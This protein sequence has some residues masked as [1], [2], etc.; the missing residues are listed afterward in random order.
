MGWRADGRKGARVAER[1]LV[2][3]LGS[4]I[5]PI[6]GGRLPGEIRVVMSGEAVLFLAY[7]EHPLEAGARV[8]IVAA[9]GSRQVDVEAWPQAR[10]DGVRG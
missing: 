5:R 9:R 1:S 10:H 7:C 2:G 6:R 4:V 3:L 8:R